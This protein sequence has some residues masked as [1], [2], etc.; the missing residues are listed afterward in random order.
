MSDAS[1]IENPADEHLPLA[2]T[3]AIMDELTGRGKCSL[4]VY[5][6]ADGVIQLSW[7]GTEINAIGMAR[8]AEKRIFGLLTEGEHSSDAP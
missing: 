2:G 8:Y 5:V 4:L 1:K 7:R 6:N 3:D